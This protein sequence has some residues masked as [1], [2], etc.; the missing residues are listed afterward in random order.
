MRSK[1]VPGL[2]AITL[3]FKRGTDS[4]EARQLVN[5][6]VAIAIPGLPASAGI[7]WVLQPLSATSRTLKIGLSSQTMSLTDLSMIAYWTISW[8]LMPCRAS[9]T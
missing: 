6:R 7:A 9:P 5:E 8:R 3:F 4:L 1:T 2:S